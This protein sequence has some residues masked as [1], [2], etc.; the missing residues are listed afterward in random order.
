M[1]RVLVLFAVLALAPAPAAQAA[2]P[3]VA[4]KRQTLLRSAAGKQITVLPLARGLQFDVRYV[5]RNVPARWE[6]ATAQVF[7][8]LTHGT[9]VLR[10]RRAGRRPRRA[11][12][13]GS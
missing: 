3:L 10:F 5:V 9:A 1:G 7:V 4:F 6:D 2:S 11:P 13:A 12:G 8:T